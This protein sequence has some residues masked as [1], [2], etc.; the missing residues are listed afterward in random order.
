[1]HR[2]TAMIRGLDLRARFVVLALLGLAC[3]PP[4]LSGDLDT[5]DVD[6]EDEDES[7][8]ESSSSS[9][10]SSGDTNSDESSTTETSTTETSITD[11]GDTHNFV[12]EYDVWEVD[13]CDSFMQDCP[14]GEKCVPYGSTGGTWDAHK[15]VPVTGDQAPGEPCTYGGVVEATDDCDA[16]SFCW[17]VM[18][19]DGEAIGTCHLF[20][21]G[22]ADMPECPPKS[23]CLISGSG[24]IN[25]CIPTCDPILQD[26][27]EG[28]ACYWA[29]GFNCIFTTQ[30]IPVGE[31]CGFINDCAAGLGCLTAEVLPSCAGSACCAPWCQLGA[32]DQQC[33]V[34]PGTTCVSFFEEGMAPPGYEHVG[35]CIVPPP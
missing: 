32:G 17:D 22:T 18:D 15:C 21:T 5:D 12:P 9:T 14:E 13:E 16:T 10:S 20:C 8:G 24:V 30:D 31:P 6:A 25:L 35:V 23:Q 27:G 29:T 7:S 4:K 11:S 33:E 2:A 3:G 34:L 19:I 26:C 28:L 1:M